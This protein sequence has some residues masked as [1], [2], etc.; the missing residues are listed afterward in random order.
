M[1][2]NNTLCTLTSTG[3]LYQWFLASWKLTEDSRRLKPI[4]LTTHIGHLPIYIQ[5]SGESFELR[6]YLL[7]NYF[8]HTDYIPHCFWWRYP[9]LA[10]CWLTD[11]RPMFLAVLV[12]RPASWRFI[13]IGLSLFPALTTWRTSY[14]PIYNYLQ[15]SWQLD[16]PLNDSRPRFS[17]AL[18]NWTGRLL[19]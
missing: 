17:A 11:L 6:P 7:A 19:V 12:T 18:G 9:G 8:I 5:A 13:I 14:W 15:T 4:L 10:I 2:I 3:D 1:C 16:Q